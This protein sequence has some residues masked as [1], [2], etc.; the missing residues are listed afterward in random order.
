MQNM[1]CELTFPPSCNHSNI[2]YYR[3]L[4]R[5]EINQHKVITLRFEIVKHLDQRF[6]KPVPRS[7]QDYPTATFCLKVQGTMI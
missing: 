2:P 7:R 5:K 4:T 6:P 1:Q 3:K